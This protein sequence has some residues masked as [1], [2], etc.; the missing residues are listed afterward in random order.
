MPRD[1]QPNQPDPER[2][3]LD[4]L[5]GTPDEMADEDLDMLY[6]A[7]APATDPAAIVHRLAEEAA[8]E[9]RTQNRLPPD[10]VQAALD[11][12][13]ELK[14]LDNLA[15]SKLRQIVDALSAPLTGAVKDPA[16]AY[17][18]RD[19]DLEGDVGNVTRDTKATAE[20]SGRGGK[21]DRPGGLSHSPIVPL[22]EWQRN[23]IEDESRFKF[24]AASV[25]SGKSFATS[26]EFC[27]N[28][29]KKPD[30]GIMLSASERQSVELMEK[31][32]MHTRAWDVKFEDGFFG[33]TEIIEHRATFPGGGRIIALPANPDT[34][35]G[36]S[37]DV[38]LDEFALHRDSRSIWAAMMTRATRGYKVRV[39][40][41]FKGTENKF[42]ELAKMLGLADGVRPEAQPV[43]R[44]GWSGHWV[45]IYMAKEQGMPVDIEGQKAAIDDEEIWLQD[46][47][48]VP[49][50]GAE[51]FIPLEL[52]LGCES[53][54][55]QLEWDGRTEPGL[56]AGF[57]VGRKRDLSVIVIGQPAADLV[58]VRGM[59]WMARMPFVR[60]PTEPSSAWP[61]STPSKKSRS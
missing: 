26:L 6:E 48:N 14:S 12:T 57:D 50:S 5:F 8:I 36:Y 55:A 21:K 20:A 41:T 18:N 53:A 23:Y 22:L 27:L 25:Q 38:F 7:I 46:Y 19:G 52:V 4:K 13:R 17:R 34:A 42:Y 37:G 35:R 10:H 2:D 31:V 15:P 39:A 29:I 11:A 30:L 16:Y 1:K 28:R 60:A 56:C 3:L 45:D 24:V 61:T 33:Q 59:I 43:E 32:K 40:S 58:V 51:N 54:E 49:M 9:Y 44:N 47:C